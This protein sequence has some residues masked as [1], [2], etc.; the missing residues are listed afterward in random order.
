MHRQSISSTQDFP[1]SSAHC[2]RYWTTWSLTRLFKIFWTSKNP[3]M[4]IFGLAKILNLRKISNKKIELLCHDA[5][6][7]NINFYDMYEENNGITCAC[8]HGA[9]QNGR[10]VKLFLLCCNFWLRWDDITQLSESPK[11]NKNCAFL[12]YGGIV[13]LPLCSVKY[14]KVVKSIFKY[15]NLHTNIHIYTEIKSSDFFYKKDTRWMEISSEIGE[16]NWFN[17]SL[18]MNI[19]VQI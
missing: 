10:V 15:L 2:T 3:T 13:K 17:F 9:S 18:N 16:L 7:E 1:R 12:R 4:V 11:A 6:L 14:I 5:K 8:V 19:S